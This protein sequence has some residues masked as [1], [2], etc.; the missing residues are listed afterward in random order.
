VNNP[1]KLDSTPLPTDWDNLQD[2]F[3]D[4][5]KFAED[6]P[7]HTILPAD[8]TGQH[9]QP[10]RVPRLG[11]TAFL[12]NAADEQAKML[13]IKLV[14]VKNVIASGHAFSDALRE[15]LRTPLGKQKLLESVIGRPPIPTGPAATT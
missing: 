5:K 2:L 15:S 13:T 9:Y 11:W 1:F 6:N 3:A 14:N 8:D 12:D 4:M 7:G 10:W